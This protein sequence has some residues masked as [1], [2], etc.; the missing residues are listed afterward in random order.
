MIAQ[1]GGRWKGDD[2]TGPL[3]APAHPA[4]FREHLRRGP[5]HKGLDGLRLVQSAEHGGLVDRDFKR[6]PGLNAE[7]R[8]ISALPLDFNKGGVD[9]LA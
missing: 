6:I 1:K 3:V 9:P 2:T 5:A 4:T 8:Q 7:L